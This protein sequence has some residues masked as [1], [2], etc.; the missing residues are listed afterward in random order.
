[1]EKK[2]GVYICKDCG[3]GDALNVEQMET[4]A[5][6]YKPALCRVHDF[7]CSQEGVQ[8]IKDDI[9]NEGINTIVIAACSMR[10]NT[11]VFSFDP[12]KYVVERVNIREHVVW[13]QP[14]Q[15]ENTQRMAEDYLRLGIMRAQK[16]NPAEPKTG[17]LEKTILVVGGGVAGLSA[18]LEA[19]K[20]GYRAIVVEKAEELGGRIKKM[21]KILPTKAPYQ[22]PETPDIEEKIKAVQEH[23]NITVYT[24]SQVVAIEGEPGMYDVTI[25]SN[26][27]V[28]TKEIDINEEVKKGGPARFP[29]P[30]CSSPETV[31]AGAIVFTIGWKPYDATKLEEP[32]GYGKYK[33]VVTNWELE[34]M[35]Y[36]GGIK[37]PSD[38]KTPRNVVFIQCAGQRDEGHLPYC[39]SVCCL[40]SLKQAKYIREAS[41]DAGAFIIYKDMR[42]PGLYEN[43]YK[44]MQDDEGIFLIKGE[45][46]GL[47]EA[48]DGTINVKVDNKLLNTKDVIKADMVVLATGMVTNM[49][50]EG[51]EPN[52]L[53]EEFIGDIVSKETE[54]GLVEELVPVPIALNLKYRQGPEMP[55]LKYGFPDSHFICFPY[56]TRRTGIYAAGAARHPMDAAQAAMDGAGAALKAIQ[57]I[58]R[59]SEGYAVHPR[60]WDQ[61]FPVFRL[62]S[63]TQCRRCT[64]ECPFGVLDEDEK[65]TPQEHPYRCRRCGTCMGA[66]PQ[67]IINFNDYNIDMISSMLGELQ[68]PGEDELFP[69]IVGFICENDA[70]PAFDMAGLNR[71]QLPP[72]FRLIR[73]RCLGGMNL[74]WISDALS[75]GVDGIILIGCK[76]GDDYQCHFIKGSQ[77]ANERL[78]KVQET[79]SR[80]MLEAERVQMVQLPINEYDKLPQILNDFAEQ[81]KEIGANP[82]KGF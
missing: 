21:K 44:S 65:A 79:L 46:T 50:P 59:T 10:V 22:E 15:D 23:P 80:L 41:P 75:K 33:N 36:S 63:C 5:N 34:E 9:E 73:L 20:T 57:C 47:E 62:E 60:S 69:F 13:T 49:L 43:F 8:V 77:M 14:P 35:A 54:D 26:D 53:T 81:V 82:Y 38:G 27:N 42:T 6:E 40:T 16:A 51:R 7:L 66:C 1:M 74:V 31:K 24:N 68:V 72:N 18:A 29:L 71:L 52:N 39:S 56:E 30:E 25:C 48:E 2:I 3:I 76:F 17:E 37:R 11:D 19:A 45:I 58:E 64:V 55:H 4:V 12:L 78:G 67:R 61:T 28:T 32:F 70:Y